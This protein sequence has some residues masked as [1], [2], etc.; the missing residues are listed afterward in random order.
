MINERKN[1]AILFVIVLLAVLLR[2]PGLSWGL[3]NQMHLWPYNTDESYVFRMFEGMEPAKLNFRPPLYLWGAF[4]VYTAGVALAVGAKTGILTLVSNR[5]FYADNPIELAKLYLTVRFITFSF[6]LI[7]LLLLH[8]LT[9]K[10]YGEF[11]ASFAIAIYSLVPLSVISSTIATPHIAE[12]CFSLATM[13]NAW[14]LQNDNSL[15]RYLWIGFF[16]GLAT[17]TLIDSVVLAVP[18]VTAHILSKPQGLFCRQNGRLFITFAVGIAIFILINPYLLMPNEA[19]NKSLNFS[20]AYFFKTSHPSFTNFFNYLSYA[21]SWPI[22]AAGLIS[23]LSVVRLKNRESIFLVSWLFIYAVVIFLDGPR[24]MRRH[25]GLLPP[26]IIFLSYGVSKLKGKI[27]LSVAAF[28]ILSAVF[29]SIAYLDLYKSPDVRTNAREWV[30]KNIPQ[31]VSIGVF[32]WHRGPHL[33]IKRNSVFLITRGEPDTAIK[34]FIATENEYPSELAL[35][36]WPGSKIINRFRRVPMLG[37]FSWRLENAPEDWL[38]TAPDIYILR[39]G[40][41]QK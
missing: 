9:K 34:Y 21:V 8:R 10:L 36:R 33:N 3:P 38:Y 15:R 11:S 35:S 32:D 41:D 20:Y 28:L 16:F 24:F 19:T 40:T 5:Q 22:I 12:L 23:I 2:L 1:S 6:W 14:S 31:G 37:P 17:S 25:I 30:D 18:I 13:I 26:L 29:P 27:R 7:S 39:V 4:Y